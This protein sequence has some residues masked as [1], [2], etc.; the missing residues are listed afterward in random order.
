ML[1]S[2]LREKSWEKPG[3][4]SFLHI[5]L[6][7]KGEIAVAQQAAIVGPHGADGFA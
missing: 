7:S 3:T 2:K 6:G 4:A 5:S 1:R